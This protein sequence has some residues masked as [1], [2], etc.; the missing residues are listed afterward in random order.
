MGQTGRELFKRTSE[1]LYR[2]RKHKKFKCLL[3]QHLAKHKHNLKYVKVQPLEVVQKQPGQSHKQFEKS[4]KTSELDWI[5][6]LQ[7][8]YPLGLNDNIMGKGNISRTSSINIMDIVD[9]RKRNLRSHGKRINRN[10][11]AKKRTDY[12]LKEL[13]LIFKNNG[14]H[15]LLCKLGIISIVKLYDIFKESQIISY[16]SPLYEGARIITAFCYHRLFPRI[17]KP[18]DHKRHFLSIKYINRGIDL[19][20]LSSIFNDTTVQN[21]IPPYFDNIEPPIISYSYKRSSRNIIFNYTSITSD[22]SIEDNTPTT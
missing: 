22:V 21:L 11:R 15:Q 18:D 14:R 20:N 3:Y 10:K 2:F 4:R 19:V 16:Y 12:S 17:D 5:K 8:A 9:K 13:L 6:K 1:H 7:T